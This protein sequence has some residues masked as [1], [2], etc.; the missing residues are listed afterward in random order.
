MWKRRILFFTKDPSSILFLFLPSFLIAG[1]FFFLLKGTLEPTM[2]SNILAVI[3]MLLVPLISVSFAGY[4]VYERE[5]QIV[6]TMKVM[7]L[8]IMPFW[9]ANVIIDQFLG[10]LVAFIMFLP[11][12]TAQNNNEGFKQYGYGWLFLM[13]YGYMFFMIMQT[14]LYGM[15]MKSAAFARKAFPGIVL[16]GKF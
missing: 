11:L 1:A 13:F 9:F 3:P 8:R 7:G 16:L 14:Y 15:F 10:A 12:W 4:L 2:Y 6:E 5:H